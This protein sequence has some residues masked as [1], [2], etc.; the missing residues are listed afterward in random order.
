MSAV[1]ESDLHDYFALHRQ[2]EVAD[3]PLRARELD[4]RLSQYKDRF[5]KEAE[6]V[7]GLLSSKQSEFMDQYENTYKDLV[8]DLRMHADTIERIKQTHRYDVE[9]EMWVPKQIAAGKKG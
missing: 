1:N 6:T 3:D 9:R 7:L 4:E 2:Y 8:F 5:H